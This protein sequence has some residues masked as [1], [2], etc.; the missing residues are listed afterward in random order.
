MNHK[1]SCVFKTNNNNY[2]IYS[3]CVCVC[4][5]VSCEVTRRFENAALNVC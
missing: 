3:A 1:Y 4:V 2:A 5:Y